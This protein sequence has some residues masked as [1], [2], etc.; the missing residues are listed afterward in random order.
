MYALLQQ[1]SAAQMNDAA[2][3]AEVAVE[4]AEARWLSGGGWRSSVSL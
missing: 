1:L 3:E 4:E 2:P